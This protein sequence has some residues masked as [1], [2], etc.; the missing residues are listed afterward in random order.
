MLASVFAFRQSDVSSNADSLPKTEVLDNS[1]IPNSNNEESLEETIDHPHPRQ[2]RSATIA[3]VLPLFISSVPIHS[4]VIIPSKQPSII[5]HRHS[6]SHRTRNYTITADPS[7]THLITTEPFQRVRANTIAVPL[8]TM[9][10][11]DRP[12]YEIRQPPRLPSLPSIESNSE[13]EEE[14]PS[15][16]QTL[17][18]TVNES[19]REKYWLWNSRFLL[20]CFSNFALC[21]VMG[22]PYV[23]L[24]TYISETF[25]NQNFLASWALSN[26]GIASAAGQILLGYLHDRKIFSAWLMYTLAV[27]LSG[28]SLIILALFRYKAIVLTCAFIY[29]LAISANYALQM[30]IVIDALSM[31]NMANAFGILQF[32]QGVSTLIGI[33][34]QGMFDLIVFLN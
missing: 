3:Q 23:I 7:A 22:V 16:P 27:S 2:S 24:P 32:C 15:L 19:P 30:L 33:P 4:S 18:E 17:L 5:H 9:R 21:L 25:H 8:Q 12:L 13:E 1:A 34:L 14:Q 6:F 28:V 26:V 29:G 11:T 10:K 20:F 31:E